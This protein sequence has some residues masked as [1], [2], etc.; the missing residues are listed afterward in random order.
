MYLI[1]MV[2]FL[3]EPSSKDIVT[4]SYTHM[5][6]KEVIEFLKSLHYWCV[7]RE[8]TARLITGKVTSVVRYPTRN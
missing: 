6:R 3:F 2:T 4:N 1:H 7:I 8:M 5:N